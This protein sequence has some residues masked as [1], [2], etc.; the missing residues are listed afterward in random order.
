MVEPAQDENRIW[1]K[2]GRGV[3]R[4]LKSNSHEFR[5]KYRTE[6]GEHLRL[7]RLC[8]CGWRGSRPELG[9]DEGSTCPYCS[10]LEDT[11]Q[12]NRTYWTV[13]LEAFGWRIFNPAKQQVSICN[14]E[15]PSLQNTDKD[16]IR[17]I[18][19]SLVR[20]WQ[21]TNGRRISP[22]QLQTLSHAF[23]REIQGLTINFQYKCAAPA[24]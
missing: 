15:N 21:I 17:R 18:A 11:T 6:S 14:L 4:F 9:I 7:F 13:K 23:R 5:V 12:T 10:D 24:C 2:I 20:A 16:Y 1:A 8:T 3:G 22:D 19:T